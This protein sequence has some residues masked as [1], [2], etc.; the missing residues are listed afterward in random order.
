MA[1]RESM[2]TATSELAKM[3]ALQQMSTLH[4]IAL[5]ITI[6]VAVLNF[7]SQQDA[8]RAARHAATR[9]DK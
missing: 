7:K 6:V 3:I 1:T 8:R 9:K 4:L 5:A 2:V